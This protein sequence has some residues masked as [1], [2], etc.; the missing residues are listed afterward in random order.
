V[1]TRIQIATAEQAGTAAVRVANIR[2]TAGAS[3]LLTV[4]ILQ[5]LQLRSEA[6]VIQLR[7]AQL[8]NRINLHRALGG[9]F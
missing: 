2:Y 5:S 9:S 3:A 6:N 4:L 8:A 1:N 7:N